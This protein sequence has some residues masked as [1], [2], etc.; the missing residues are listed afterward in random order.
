MF[1][2]SRNKMR[3][4]FGQNP[5]FN[6][7]SVQIEIY[8]MNVKNSAKCRK[9]TH[10]ENYKSIQLFLRKVQTNRYI[11]FHFNFKAW[12]VCISIEWLR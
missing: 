12:S 2:S 1:V 7:S 10:D 8:S 4:I 5:K 9:K 3:N 6:E 11:Y